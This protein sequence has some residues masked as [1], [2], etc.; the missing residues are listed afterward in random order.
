MVQN[1]FL[2]VLFVT[3]VLFVT[4]IF[5]VNGHFDALNINNRYRRSTAQDIEEKNRNKDHVK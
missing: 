4:L 2:W 1:L 3:N 5:Q